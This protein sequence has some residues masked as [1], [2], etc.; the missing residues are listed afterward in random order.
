MYNFFQFVATIILVV[1][2]SAAIAQ[3][4]QDSV[5]KELSLKEVQIHTIRKSKQPG[6]TFYQSSLL[7]STEDIL[8]RVEGVNLIRRGP[9]GMEPVLRGFSAGQINVVI[10]G[11]RIFGAC[12]DKM[13]PAT[14]YTE[15]VNLKSIDIKY[16]GD[17]IGTGATIG[18][19]LNLK[20][21][22]A[23]IDSNSRFTG[24]LASGYY[25]AATA[26]QNAVVMNYSE[27][28]WAIRFSGVY[29]KGGDYTDGENKKVDFSQYGKMNTS[30]S[31][32]YQFNKNSTIKADFI[33]DDGWNIGFPALAMDV[34]Y[35][36]ARIASV[37]YERNN[38]AQ[39]M[40][41]IEAKIYANAVRHAMDDT[42]RPA[43]AMHMDMPGQSHT[44]GAFL[45]FRLRK[46]GIH[47]FKV[48]TDFY[49]N[50]VYADMTMYPKDA[51]PMFMLTWPKNHQKVAGLFVEDE[52]YLSSM[53]R[54]GLK[55][56]IEAVNAKVTDE[57]GQD[58]FSVLGYDVH[59]PV[60]QILKNVNISYTR[61]LSSV[62]TAYLSAGFNE[63]SPTTSER[64]GFYLFNQMDNHDY[65]GNP[66]LK[67]E[68][69]WNGEFNLLF[70]KKDFSW[71]LSAFSSWVAH[72]IMGKTQQSLSV[73]TIGA[74]GVRSYENIP[75]ARLFG[76]E[77]S[78]SYQLLNRHLTFNNTWKWLRG[79]DNEKTPLPLMSPL[80]IMTSV[81]FQHRTL[82]FQVENEICSK[83]N[84]INIDFGESVSPGYTLFHIRSGYGFVIKKHKLDFS[85]GIE[86]LLNKAYADHLDWGAILR[87][88]RNIY[89]LLTFK[90]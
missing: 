27:K 55:L 81:R 88:G 4:Q 64:F 13:D 45:Q 43:T 29:R 75:S 36:K 46:M 87:P 6:T 41:E 77:S 21:A 11:M 68:Q 1:S 51:A 42:K 38:S 31:G 74:T 85:A 57:M 52:M 73:M 23:L 8:A 19:T 37:T 50:S 89:G 2:T 53:S 59:R 40:Q 76:A 90:F 32:K 30:V 28:K 69:A 67:N 70:A 60:K 54:L 26:V 22:D 34:G 79:E 5:I 47:N 16:G 15:P 35:A 44:F 39:F 48:K 62:L 17:G 84:Q 18:G 9:I 58:Q 12:T 83:Q 14:I 72:Y 71:K 25:S 56:R 66:L 20:L 86:N 65:V 63:R 82:S 33:L 78:F 10:D 24:S 49:Y 3:H 80:K 7:A 61:F